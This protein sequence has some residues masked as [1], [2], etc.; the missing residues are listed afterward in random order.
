MMIEYQPNRSPHPKIAS[1]LQGHSMQ[2]ITTQI[3]EQMSICR[4]NATATFRAASASTSEA[5]AAASPESAA[6]PQ[7]CS[8]FL[9]R[10][11]TFSCTNTSKYA[12]YVTLSAF[13]CSELVWRPDTAWPFWHMTSHWLAC[14]SGCG[15][16]AQEEGEGAGK[17]PQKGDHCHSRHAGHP[18]GADSEG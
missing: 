10:M 17:H 6:P 11:S 14:L 4:R 9:P 1:F 8:H 5:E 3:P 18:R 12:Y 15:C 13:Q 7:V 2:T 16:R